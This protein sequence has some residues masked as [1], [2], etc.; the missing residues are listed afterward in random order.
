MT[1]GRFYERSKQIK[2][3]LS[4]TT[5]SAV[6]GDITC[7]VRLLITQGDEMLSVKSKTNAFLA[8]F[9]LN[10]YFKSVVTLLYDIDKF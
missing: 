1:S 2:I 6:D 4:M 10:L 3:R 5:D 9:S 7:M 8:I